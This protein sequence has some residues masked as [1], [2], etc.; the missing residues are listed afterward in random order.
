M[1]NTDEPKTPIRTP[2]AWRAKLGLTLVIIAAVIGQLFINSLLTGLGTRVVAD[3]F[4]GSI[5]SM[6]GEQIRMD[7]ED[8]AQ[9]Q[10]DAEAI[11]TRLLTNVAGT[12]DG[13]TVI[14]EP[15]L[16][17]APCDLPGQKGEQM[18]AAQMTTV[19]E[20]ELGRGAAVLTQIAALDLSEMAPAEW[21][22]DSREVRR[23]TPHSF[24]HLEAQVAH[25]A[26]T[27]TLEETGA[28]DRLH[29][30]ASEGCYIP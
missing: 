8:R 9:I 23:P 11:A 13:G 14:S 15:V 1:T 7:G 6:A 28:A 19:I 10:V 3:V 2:R 18:Y 20:V 17:A 26:V 4:I 22:D 12:I 16:S 29:I 5:W 24:N 25:D 30:V 21:S 27:I